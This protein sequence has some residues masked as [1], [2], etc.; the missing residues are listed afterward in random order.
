M[1][2]KPDQIQ[3]HEIKDAALEKGKF[4]KKVV[5][6]AAGAPDED[7]DTG[8]GFEQGTMWIDSSNGAMYICTDHTAED[9]VWHNMEGDDINLVQYTSGSTG[10]IM[11]GYSA[12]ASPATNITDI[13][14]FPLSSPG[15]AS[16]SGDELSQ[17]IYGGGNAKSPTHVFGIGGRGGS[18][19]IYRSQIDAY[20]VAGGS[21]STDW[22]DL[23]TPRAYMQGGSSPSYGYGIGGY[24][25]PPA[26]END[27]ID[28]FAT[29]SPG[30][31]SDFG[32]LTTGKMDGGA[33]SDTITSYFFHFGGREPGP[34]YVTDIDKTAMTSPSNA[35]DT[36]A[37]L[38]EA[39]AENSSA[40][41]ATYGYSIGGSPNQ[42]PASSVDKI[43]KFA[44][45]STADAS[46]IGNLTAARGNMNHEVES[47]THG[48]GVGGQGPGDD[49]ILDRFAFA[50]DGDA[51]DWGNT[52]ETDNH[53][54]QAASV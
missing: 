54:N 5:H 42:D 9:S 31:A 10:Y 24:Y 11:T 19:S 17:N 52:V 32:N 36:G 8:S 44:L 1:K 40:I 14:S 39:I 15:N 49:N 38:V 30:G 25:T 48:F 34:A 47:S 46:D 16:D 51:A 27:T 33:I 35:S 12:S 3:T 23:S 26:S 13:S 2:Y 28:R 45:S 7:D 6:V 22:G 18:P 43:T 29:D 4:S 20:A 50:S 41:S 21:N 53:Y 37:E